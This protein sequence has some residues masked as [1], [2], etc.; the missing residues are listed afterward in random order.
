MA[1]SNSLDFA[2]TRDNLI[3]MAMQHVN[4]IGEVDT[5]SSTQ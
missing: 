4:A 2:L 5:P 1:T 3:T